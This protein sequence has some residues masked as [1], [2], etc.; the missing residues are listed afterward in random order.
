MI[1]A[2]FAVREL[3][4]AENFEIVEPVPIDGLGLVSAG[5]RADRILGKALLEGDV[6]DGGIDETPRNPG[7]EVGGGPTPKRRLKGRKLSDEPSVGK[8]EALGGDLQK[9]V[10]FEA[11]DVSKEYGRVASGGFVIERTGLR[12]GEFVGFV[13]AGNEDSVSFVFDVV[14]FKVGNVEDSGEEFIFHVFNIKRIA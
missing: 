5:D 3:V 11:R 9:A 10:S 2:T 13:L 14:D 7:V 8:P 4:D 12:L 6:G 1:P